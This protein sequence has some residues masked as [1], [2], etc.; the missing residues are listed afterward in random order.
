M[1]RSMFHVSISG[2]RKYTSADFA[3]LLESFFTTGVFDG[4]DTLRAHVNGNDRV[5]RLL[6]GGGMLKG[7]FFFEDGVPDVDFLPSPA[8]PTNSRYDRVVVRWDGSTGVRDI[9]IEYREGV[10]SATPEPPDLHRDADEHEISL[11]KVHI[12]AGSSTVQVT[13]LTDERDIGSLCGRVRGAAPQKSDKF[14]NIN[15]G[16]AIA[17]TGNITAG[18][19]ITATGTI[20]GAIV[21]GAVYGE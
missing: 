20:Q 6:P 15:A 18:G 1:I 19:N 11:A 2:D 17:A 5:V 7:R 13:D 4:D 14:K 12:R 10:P 8:D 3:Y 16:G 21:K 9:T